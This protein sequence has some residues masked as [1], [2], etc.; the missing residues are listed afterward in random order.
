MKHENWYMRVSEHRILF[1]RSVM[2][3]WM[4]L[5]SFSRHRFPSRLL[6]PVYTHI[7][8]QLLQSDD[9]YFMRRVRNVLSKWHLLKSPQHLRT[10]WSISKRELWLSIYYFYRF[11]WMFTSLKRVV[12]WWWLIRW[13]GEIPIPILLSLTV[14]W[15]HYF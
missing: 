1:R 9:S 15:A 12:D 6:S 3:F 8:Y 10:V 2:M 11:F 5:L 7:F 14:Y 13:I 4:W